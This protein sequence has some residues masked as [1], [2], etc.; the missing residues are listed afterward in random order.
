MKWGYVFIAAIFE[1]CWVMGLKYASTLGEW[2]AT[3]VCIIISFTLLLKATN[4]LPV[5]S[6][7][8]V[9]TGL[10]TAGTVILGMILGE[11]VHVGKL[12]LIM[13]LLCGVL[14]LKLTTGDTKGETES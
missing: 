2:S 3:I 7:Y 12:L 11:P 6:L 10:G 13:M 8:A 4:V 9:F 5:G 1:V 14:G